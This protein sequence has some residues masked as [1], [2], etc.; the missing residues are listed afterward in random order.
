[1]KIKPLI[2]ILLV[3]TIVVIVVAVAGV[4]LYMN[5][6]ART[7]IEKVLAYV[8]Q[9]DVSLGKV[10]LALKEGK[11]DLYDLKIGNPE[12]F[13][14]PEAFS[15]ARASIDIDIGSLRSDTRRI[16]LIEI[17]EPRITLEQDIS[18]SNIK[19]LIDNASRFDTGG[20]GESEAGSKESQEASSKVIIDKVRVENAHVT[21][22]SSLLPKN[23]EFGLP[24]LELNDIGKEGE[25]VTVAKAITLF[26]QKVLTSSLAAGKGVIPDD[27]S[28][29]LGTGVKAVEQVLDTGKEAVEETVST[30]TE[31][32]KKGLTGLFGKDDGDD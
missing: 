23:I 9:V 16:T 10:D 31:G 14:T 11:A 2:K 21:V 32:I 6:L 12:G 22:A 8:L 29:V 28:E 20:T 18:K 25:G 24:I 19:Q 26:L 30:V 27:V 7:A 17:V 1:M 13:K 15:F 4:F 5:T 3:V